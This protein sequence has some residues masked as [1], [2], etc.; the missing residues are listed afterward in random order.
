MMRRTRAFTLCLLCGCFWKSV[1]QSGTAVERNDAAELQSRMERL[2][3]AIDEAQARVEAEQ[4]D[5]VAL[6]DE[7]RALQA[8]LQTP[9]AKYP[10]ESPA[11]ITAMSSSTTNSEQQDM[12]VSQIATLDQVKVE[13]L[14]KYPVRVY[15]TILL[16]GF[17]NS[18]GVDEAAAPS[19]SFGGQGSTGLAVRQT[20]LGLDATGPRLLG[21]LSRADVTV[22][23]FGAT[24][25]AGY[26]NAGGLVRLRTAHAVLAWKSTEAFFAYDRPLISPY[27]P[28]SLVAAA[29]PEL[30]WSGNLW[31]WN[32]QAGVSHTWGSRLRTQAA[33]IDAADPGYGAGP[34]AGSQPS[35]PSLAEA[36]RFPGVEARVA[37]AGSEEGDGFSVGIGGYFAPHR[38][39]TSLYGAGSN[40]NAWASTLDL[41]LPLPRRLSFTASAYRGEALGGLGGGGYRDYVYRHQGSGIA[42][43]ALDDVGGWA[44]LHQA[45]S[46]KISWNVG[47]GL[48]N[49][50]ARQLRAYPG[51]GFQNLYQNIARNRT[52]FANVLYSPRAYL[53]FS[54]EYRNLRTAPIQGQLWT[55][56]VT[57]LGAAY[58]F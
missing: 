22:D 43:R 45:V 19:A 23:F 25:S 3:H 57:G 15:G 44:Q 56:N 8:A 39:S 55:T 18:S 28:E 54:A 50:F 52:I 16:N 51:D 58:R 9:G 7:A 40:F 30:A 32:P 5:L 42:V 11:A 38:F 12:L 6:R 24:Q 49:P 36:S 46:Q 37:L 27:K 34:V 14:S 21:A 26:A 48:D 47:F 41:R 2:M 29:V 31:S 35:P 1:A 13:T 4:K 20:S 17:A 53:I 33:L 10:A